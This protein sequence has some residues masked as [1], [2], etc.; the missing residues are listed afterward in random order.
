MKELSPLSEED[1]RNTLIA[2]SDYKC[3]RCNELPK[4]ACKGPRK[5]FERALLPRSSLD[6]VELLPVQW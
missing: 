6:E 2:L 1:G 4:I 3:M 5:P